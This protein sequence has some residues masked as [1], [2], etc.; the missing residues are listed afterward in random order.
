M[1]NICVSPLK[2]EMCM[3]INNIKNT[4]L[5]ELLQGKAKEGNCRKKE[6]FTSV[7]N[8]LSVSGFRPP[9]WQQFRVA[10]TLVSHCYS[11]HDS[12]GTASG[13]NLTSFTFHSF[14]SPHSVL[15][16]LPGLLAVLL[17]TTVFLQATCGFTA[18][19]NPVYLR[20]TLVLSDLNFL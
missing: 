18:V 12:G 1:V 8:I 15:T 20:V 7:L 6:I 5:N 13:C 2:C 11:R 16:V 9:F 10:T 4:W 14:G 19:A 3:H 17:H